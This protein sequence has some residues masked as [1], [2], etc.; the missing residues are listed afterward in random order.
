MQ[1][2][3]SENIDGQYVWLEEQEAK[4]CVQVLR[5]KEGDTIQIID[6]K[7]SLFEGPIVDIAKKKCSIEIARQNYFEPIAPKIHL[8]IAPT[9]NLSRIEWFVEKATELGVAE[10]TFLK[11][12]HSERKVLKLERLQKVVVTASKQSKRMHFPK[13]NVLTDFSAWMDNEI[14]SNGMKFIAHCQEGNKK[15]IFES[16]GRGKDVLILIGPEGDFSPDE[17]QMAIKNGYESLSLGNQRLRTETAAVASVSY[18]SLL[19]HL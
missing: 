1:L 5:K 19:N 17:I 4:H 12:Q 11:C 16:V 7:G 8:A 2:F 9:K 18:V 10:I 3:Y 13:L 14:A 6:G 15:S